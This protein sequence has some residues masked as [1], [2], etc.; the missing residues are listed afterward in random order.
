MTPAD[1]NG[2]E[3]GSD[4]FVA[5][6]YVLGVLPADERQAAAA[7]VETDPAFARL[8]D[9]WELRLSP[10]A[11]AYEL[12]EPPAEL[13]QA[14]DRR[15]FTGAA[16][17]AEPRAG[18][19]QSLAFWRGLAALATAAF[20][21]AIAVSVLQP[22]AGEPEAR[23]LVASVAPKDSDVQYVAVYDPATEEIG[24]SHVA[25][26]RPQGKD[27]ELWVIVGQN[28]PV[29]LGVI[30]EG[31]GVHLPVNPATRDDLEAGALFAISVEPQGG[32]P[33]GK[34]TGPIVAAGGLN[35]I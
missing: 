10:I 30:P 7:R 23:Q 17:A 12:A 11:D 16:S 32:A 5:A 28:A 29:S 18:M 26:E 2:P 20:V 25:G 33:E 6:E 19:W 24:L 3:P 8:V 21:I 34:P 13:K 9:A 27:F 14:L 4:E 35:A 31:Q 1:D 15:L 22:P